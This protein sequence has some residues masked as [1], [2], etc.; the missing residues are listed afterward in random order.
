MGVT[1][2]TDGPGNTAILIAS[3]G[4]IAAEFCANLSLNGY[5]DWYLPAHDELKVMYTN[6]TATPFATNN[7][8]ASIL[9]SIHW[10]SSEDSNGAAWEVHLLSNEAHTDNPETTEFNVRAVRREPY[11]VL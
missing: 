5:T 7:G 9:R 8:F 6:R 1:S 2:L 4:H 3:P 10:S 11:N